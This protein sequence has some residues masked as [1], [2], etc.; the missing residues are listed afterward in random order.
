MKNEYKGYRYCFIDTETTGTDPKKHEIYQLSAIIT[1]V[2][3]H[4]LTKVDLKF[5]PD[6]LAHELSALEVGGI[7][8]D[9]LKSFKMS[10][11]EA[12]ETFV[13]VLANECDKF[14]KKD[15]M[16][17]VAYN[18]RFDADFVR[19]FFKKNGDDYFGSWFWNPPL[20]VM[21]GAAWYAQRVRGAFPDFKLGTV[22]KCAELG[23]DQLQAH[24][25]LYDVRKTIELFRHLRTNMDIL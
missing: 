6:S 8:L 19:E 21:S 18:A 15:K 24:D 22:C 2:N 4:E 20:C 1:D 13:A 5:R 3:F 16:H 23:W 14:N 9:N 11:K 10:S 7:T 12:Y 17:F 25:A